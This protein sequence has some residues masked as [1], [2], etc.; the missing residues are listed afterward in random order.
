M[1][2]YAVLGESRRPWLDADALKARYLALSAASHPDRFHGAPETERLEAGRRAMEINAAHGILSEPRARLLHLLELETGRRP[3]DIQRIPPGT[4]DLF[5]E[6]G[7]CCRD[8]DGFLTERDAVTS[9]V[10]KVRM[11][12]RGMEWVERLRALQETVRA[13]GAGLEEELRGMNAAWEGAPAE[14]ASGRAGCLP[15]GR[16]EEIYRVLSYVARWT[17]QIQERVV[18]LAAV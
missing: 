8:V 7:Q 3:A 18:R 9:P 6:V 4:M 14:G 15:L 10:L 12:E 17:E 16:L 13:K 11:F 1:D 5:V 2:A